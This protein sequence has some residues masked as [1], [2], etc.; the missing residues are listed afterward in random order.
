VRAAATA[1]RAFMLGWLA[2][3]LVKAVQIVRAEGLVW[4]EAIAIVALMVLLL[5]TL[6][7]GPVRAIA[8]DPA[9][10]LAC[11]VSVGAMLGAVMLAPPRA[12][13]P[14]T[15]ALQLAAAALM[16][17]SA[18]ALGRSITLLPAAIAPVSAGPYALVRHPLYSAYLLFDLALALALQH[19]LVWT[20]LALEVLALLWRAQVEERVL[21]Q[22]FPDYG[23]YAARVRGR[24]IPWVF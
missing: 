18:L 6:R 19:W 11:L 22:S 15:D 4:A 2:F 17:W 21:L 16:L 13:T 9:T 1:D 14:L 24:L 10:I 7:R 3:D 5:N 23:G 20:A 12:M 8:A